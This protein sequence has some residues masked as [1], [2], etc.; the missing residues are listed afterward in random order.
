MHRTLTGP[1]SPQLFIASCVTD[2]MLHACS[3]VSGNV[4]LIALRIL[5]KLP[6]SSGDLT[7]TRVSYT[8]ERHMFHILVADGLTYLVVAEEVRGQPV[9]LC[10]RDEPGGRV[11]R[12]G[13]H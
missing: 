2:F 8:Q 9:V 11:Q 13:D 12:D 1:K 10:R 3:S 4:P 6:T 5:E 7:T